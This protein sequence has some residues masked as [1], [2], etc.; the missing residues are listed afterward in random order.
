MTDTIIHSD[1]TFTQPFSHAEQQLITQKRSCFFT[2]WSRGFPPNGKGC[3]NSDSNGSSSMMQVSFLIL[4]WKPLPFVKA[5]GVSAPY[6]MTC[7]IAVLKSPDHKMVINALNANVKVFMADFEDSLTPKWN[8]LIEGQ[9]TLSEA[10]RGTLSF[11]SETGK[12]YQLRADPAVL[13]CRVRGLHLDEKHVLWQGKAIPG[14]L[15]DF[16]LYFFHNAAALLSKDSGPYCRA[17]PSRP[18]YLSK[19]CQPCSRWMRSCGTCAT[20]LLALTVAAGKAS[21]VIIALK[22]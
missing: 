12:I 8:K 18:R 19:P 21:R 20:I 17:A 22:R 1:L 4:I 6:Q 16:A 9:Q 10:V 11:T 2:S 13:M 15:F 14:G 7:V 5:T 3:S